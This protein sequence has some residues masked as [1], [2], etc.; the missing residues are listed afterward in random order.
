LSNESGMPKGYFGV[1]RFSRRNRCATLRKRA[2]N[3]IAG[4]GIDHWP[5]R[6]SVSTVA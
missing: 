6:A 3:A 4:R 1:V 2:K 5:W